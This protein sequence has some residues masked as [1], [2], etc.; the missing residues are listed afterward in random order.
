MPSKS[1]TPSKITSKTS[2]T[3]KTL[4]TPV[5]PVTTENEITLNDNPNSYYIAIVLII[6]SIGFSFFILNWLVKVN[7]CK[8]ANID[9][10]LYLKEWYMFLI[11][12]QII[13]GIYVISTSDYQP[14]GILF[15]ISTIVNLVAFVMIVRLLLYISKLKEIKC[16]C[17]MTTQENIIYYFY[18]VVYSIMLAIILLGILGALGTLFLHK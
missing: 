6:L 13:A 7:K 14:S 16:D 15:V 2:M 11:V 5:T 17:G 1:K 9:E 10:A 4:I 18:I 8:C 3:P 12:Y